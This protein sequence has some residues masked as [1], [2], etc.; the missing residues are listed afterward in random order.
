MKEKVLSILFFSLAIVLFISGFVATD[1]GISIWAIIAADV[2]AVL[3]AVTVPVRKK[4]HK[5]N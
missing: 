1:G 5:Y 2:F 4:K 3:G